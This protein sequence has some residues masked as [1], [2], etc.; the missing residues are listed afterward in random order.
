MPHTSL[1]CTGRPMKLTRRGMMHDPTV[2]TNPFQFKPERFLSVEQGGLSE[3]DPIPTVF[4][5]GRRICPGM[6]LA[7]A[8]MWTYSACV[9]AVFKIA[10]VKDEKGEDV[11]PVAETGEG[12][13]RYVMK[14]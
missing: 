4:G 9:L 13:I 14:L 3:P 1:V 5:F 2:Y 12:I 8:S 7:A 10:P 11:V 6:H